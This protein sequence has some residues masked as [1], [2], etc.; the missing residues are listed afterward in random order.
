METSVVKRI[1]PFEIIEKTIKENN[2][3]EIRLLPMRRKRTETLEQFLIKFFTK[4]NN[5]KQTIYADDKTVQTAEGRRRSLGDIYML[6]KYYLPDCTLGETL[7]LLYVKLFQSM[8]KGFRTS[9]CRQTHKR[10]WYFDS[11]RVSEIVTEDH[12]D[13]FGKPVS[14]YLKTIKSNEKVK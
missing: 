2:P 6:C 10:M 5:E 9:Y 7:S 4:W 13:E 3:R 1:D 12:Q 8:P 11:R 14:F